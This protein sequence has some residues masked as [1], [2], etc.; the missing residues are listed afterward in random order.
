MGE[1]CELLVKLVDVVKVNS[2]LDMDFDEFFA[3]DGPTN[4]I[5]NMAAFLGIDPSK[6]KIAKI[7]EGS[8]IID[9]VIIPFEFEDVSSDAPEPIVV[10]SAE[11]AESLSDSDESDSVVKDVVIEEVSI[12]EQVIQ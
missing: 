4:F 3:T 11:D 9:F 5:D 12:E 1:D 8:V 7:T 2:K 10:N 6:I